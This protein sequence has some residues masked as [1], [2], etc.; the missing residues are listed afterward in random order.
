M[1]KSSYKNSA[2]LCFSSLFQMKVQTYMKIIRYTN[3]KCEKCSVN[4]IRNY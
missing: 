4:G 3:K 1:K 2:D